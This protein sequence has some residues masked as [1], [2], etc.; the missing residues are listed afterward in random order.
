V[1]S[2][3]A[4]GSWRLRHTAASIVPHAGFHHLPKDAPSGPLS[5]ADITLD[6]AGHPRLFTYG[7]PGSIEGIPGPLLT[8]AEGNLSLP[9][10]GHSTMR[11]RLRFAADLP[12]RSGRRSAPGPEYLAFP[13]GYEDVRDL[14]RTIL[15]AGGTAA[16][17]AERLLRFFRTGFRYTLTRPAPS[18]RRFLF[19]EKA[20]YCEHYAAGLALL[21]RA[22]GI[23]SRVAAGY[24]GGEWNE[25]GRYLIVRQSDAHAWVEAWIDGRWVTLDATPPQGEESP[26]FRR[27]GFL[28]LHV[29][30]LRQRWDKYVVNYSM[31]TQAAAVAGGWS[32]IR[33]TRRALERGAGRWA[34][35]AYA[36]AAFA[37]AAAAAAWFFSYRRR[38]RAGRR[39]GQ[40]RLPAPY[41]RLLQRLERCGYRPVQ[42]LPMESML[43]AAVAAHPDLAGDAARFLAAYHRDRFGPVPPDPQVRAEA[44]R[45]AERLGKTISPP[46]TGGTPGGRLA[47]RLRRLRRRRR[48]PTGGRSL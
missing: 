31:R 6:P 46:A 32:T 9:Q 48:T 3:Y 41:G 43:E 25:Y 10:A 20:G 2:R 23:P 39:E 36:G 44:F 33:G 37:G 30:W 26:F 47:E 24:L 16:E 4:D 19:D 8:D 17:R 42:G 15:G 45:R 28:G 18:L 1:Y 22:G 14:A 40:A 11:Y 34:P 29:D 5:V 13:D 12:P 27:T 35:A 7:Y 38:R 21:L